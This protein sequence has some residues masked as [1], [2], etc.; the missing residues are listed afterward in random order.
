[1]CNDIGISSLK[2]LI[3]QKFPSK[4]IDEQ[5][6]DFLFSSKVIERK[7]LLKAIIKVRYHELLKEGNTARSSFLDCAVEF[8]VSES[9]VQK[10][11]YHARDIKV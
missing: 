7:N 1:M 5:V 6:F 2:Q 11:I 10:L 3:V 8:G 4:I 9:F